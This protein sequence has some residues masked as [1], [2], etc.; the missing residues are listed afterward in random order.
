[1]PVSKILDTR[2]VTIN[3]P[4]SNRKFEE[5]VKKEDG[6]PFKTRLLAFRRYYLERALPE[7]LKPAA[8]RL[9]DILKPIL[10]VATLV[11]PEKNSEIL[12]LVRYIE[13]ERLI[14]K[15]D[16]FEAQILRTI[17]SLEDKVL[18]GILSNMAITDAT[19][20]DRPDRHKLSYHKV[21][22]I[23]SAMGFAKSR[24]NEGA[25]AIIW[26]DAKIER[27]FRSYGLIKTSE[28]SEIS[29][30]PV[31]LDGNTDITDDTD[32]MQEMLG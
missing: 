10:Q 13:G 27:L 2:A 25:S 22:R 28:T 4:E 14:E 15:S 23:L 17:L 29:E 24:T 16:S 32:V 11:N 12:D 8:G 19:N 9:G 31:K 20:K 1:M 18:N 3:M 21:G 26:D 30:T 7:T 5:E 6:L